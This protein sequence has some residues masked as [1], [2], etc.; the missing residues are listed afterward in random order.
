MPVTHRVGTPCLKDFWVGRVNCERCNAVAPA[1][2]D[3]LDTTRFARPLGQVEDYR[4]PVGTDIVLAGEMARNVFTIRQG[5]VKLWRRIKDGNYRI[6]RLLRPGD[7][8]GLEALS[9][10]HYELSATSITAVELCRIP[11]D[12]LE[13]LR[14]ETSDLHAELDKR[15][16]SQQRRTD[17]LLLSIATGPSRERVIKLLRYLAQFAAPGPSPRLRRLDMA[18]MLDISSETAARVIADLKQAG[19]LEE[20][21]T[22]LVFDPERL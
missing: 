4:A 19:M 21:P 22:Q 5:F 6:V 12:V 8:L 9:Q 17:E 20:T 18:A 7:I 3:A 14:R 15:R 13:K 1:A 16:Q 2:F 11:V 10:P